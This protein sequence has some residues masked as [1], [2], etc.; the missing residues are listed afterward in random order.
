MG[1]R[2]HAFKNPTY[3]IFFSDARSWEK[4]L[5]RGS[6]EFRRNPFNSFGRL[7][8]TTRI[9]QCLYLKC[10]GS[11]SAPAALPLQINQEIYLAPSNSNSFDFL[12]Y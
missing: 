8:K 11:D 3:R 10:I 4:S 1:R 9:I 6:S 2:Y 5:S 7:E 12:S